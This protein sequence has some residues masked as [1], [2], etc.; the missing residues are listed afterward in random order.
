[1]LQLDLEVLRPCDQKVRQRC[2][3]LLFGSLEAKQDIMCELAQEGQRAGE[4][5]QGNRE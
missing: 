3:L 2:L 5:S 4:A 1:V